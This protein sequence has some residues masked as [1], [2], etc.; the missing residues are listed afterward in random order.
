M[1][2]MLALQSANAMQSLFTSKEGWNR[3]TLMAFLAIIC[4]NSL[5]NLA[6]STV[7][8]ILG[9][10][11][12]ALLFV[13]K[14]SQKC[15]FAFVRAIWRVFMEWPL[16]ISRLL[17]GR[18]GRSIV[19]DDSSSD[20][21]SDGETKSERNAATCTISLRP[22]IH[23]WNVILFGAGTNNTTNATNATKT[24]TTNAL[25]ASTTYRTD[26]VFRVSQSN[27]TETELQEILTDVC[28]RTRDFEA[29]F[30]TPLRVQSLV[31]GGK[32]TLT[33]VAND[34]P[35]RITID[36]FADIA[37][38]KFRPFFAELREAVTK[39]LTRDPYG[40]VANGK[41]ISGRVSSPANWRSSIDRMAA[42]GIF[43]RDAPHLCVELVWISCFI[44]RDKL[45]PNGNAYYSMHGLFGCEF[46]T[47]F[48]ILGEARDAVCKAVEDFPDAAKVHDW[49]NGQADGLTT[50]IISTE[51]TGVVQSASHSSPLPHRTPITSDSS[52]HTVVVRPVRPGMTTSEELFRAWNKYV[53]VCRA[54]ADEVAR[55]SAASTPRKIFSLRLASKE[56]VEMVD[57]PAYATYAKL[58]K[59][60]K[61]WASKAKG[62]DNNKGGG[63]DDDSGEGSSDKKKEK[64][65]NLDDNGKDDGGSESGSDSDDGYYYGP[66]KKLRQVR[67]E[68]VTDTTLVNEIR[69]DLSTLYMRERDERRLHA[70]LDNFKHRSDRL[71]KLGIANKLGV[72][73]YGAPGTGKSSTIQAIAT[74]LDKD[75]YYLHLNTART[76]SDLKLAFDHVVKGCAGG[77][78]IVVME[79]V[80]AMTDVVKRRSAWEVKNE[81][82]IGSDVKIGNDENDPLTLEY[83]LN[84]LQGSL[85]LDGTV[86]LATTNKLDDL[87]E[88]F[89][90]QGRF[91]VVIEM[92]PC[93]RYQIARMF[94]QF[95]QRPLAPD[96]LDRV[97]EDVHIPASLIARFVEFVFTA[98]GEDVDDRHILE[99]FL[100][101][102]SSDEKLSG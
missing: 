16:R 45:M 87:D 94:E 48:Q 20:A 80:D 86:F 89:Y 90:R 69:R 49:L 62:K 22:S 1:D 65:K 10:R 12:N 100:V 28:V 53:E 34:T 63:D 93:D 26:D 27:E 77:G 56:V 102:E 21:G 30:T 95:F 99:P 7:D 32:K 13:T 8:S 44:C 61:A 42:K 11:A 57:N 91:D 39:A 46:N 9:Q 84:I 58:A 15:W 72:M 85:T 101:A 76:N 54:E 17:F 5:K 37:P 96:L 3:N 24:T 2:Q 25:G 83:L 14:L 64:E 74:A 60:R 71:R 81:K 6:D 73:L 98:D 33:S 92:R 97:R 79:D 18:F 52:H 55:A 35:L 78:G 51:R 88:A 40:M 38:Q 47:T 68:R 29:A 66:P 4:M 70:C 19:D 43:A 75:L 59:K 82:R 41:S 50:A 31:R 67:Y 36:S 23:T